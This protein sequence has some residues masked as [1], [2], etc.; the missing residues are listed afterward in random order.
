MVA[1]G[2]RQTQAFSL[3]LEKEDNHSSLEE[4]LQVW[5]RPRG[6]MQQ[7]GSHHP[8]RL[9]LGVLRNHL[10]VPSKDITL[11]WYFESEDKHTNCSAAT[12]FA[13]RQHAAFNYPPLPW[14]SC[15]TYG[16]A[17]CNCSLVTCPRCGGI[18]PGVYFECI[19]GAF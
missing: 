16:L 19:M 6:G 12:N 14:N 1:S 11:F 15:G 5:P 3:R 9:H 4:N 2:N 18:L 17:N 8:L 13:P 7:V 10:P